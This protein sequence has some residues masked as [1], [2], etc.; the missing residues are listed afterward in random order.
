MGKCVENWPLHVS[1]N[2][3]NSCCVFIAYSKLIENKKISEKS[4]AIEKKRNEA[5]TR[6][7]TGITEHSRG[8]S[9]IINYART[10]T[11]NK[12]HVCIGMRA[13]R[14]ALRILPTFLPEKRWIKKFERP[15]SWSVRPPDLFCNLVLLK[16]S[17]IF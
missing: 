17:S 14:I 8:A 9:R 7:F 5:R 3:S 15:S 1:N 16:T 6:I 2:H 4:A 11:N 10:V 13:D 12:P